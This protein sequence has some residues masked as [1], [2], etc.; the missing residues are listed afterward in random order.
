MLINEIKMIIFL[1]KCYVII[2]L[3]YIKIYNC[4]NLLLIV[5]SNLD[6]WII[7]VWVIRRYC[8]DLFFEF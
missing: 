1:Y 2:Y 6:F 4:F 7:Y 3:F 5:L 8:L